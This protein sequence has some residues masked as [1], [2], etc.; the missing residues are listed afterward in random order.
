MAE[1]LDYIPT[2]STLN[3][4]LWGEISSEGWV[5]YGNEFEK[6]GVKYR[7]IKRDVQE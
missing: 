7:S 2:K 5:I 3:P 6:D 4:R 1:Q